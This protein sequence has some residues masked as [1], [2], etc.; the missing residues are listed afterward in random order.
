MVSDLTARE[1]D[2]SSPFVDDGG[3]AF[4]SATKHASKLI[5]AAS[6]CEQDSCND[7]YEEDHTAYDATQDRI[8]FLCSGAATL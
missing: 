2:R 6:F 5:R 1:R 7:H 8:N 4:V 3:I